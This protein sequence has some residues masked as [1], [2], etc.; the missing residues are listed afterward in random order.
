MVLAFCAALG[1]AIGVVVVFGVQSRGFRVA[2]DATARLN[3]LIFS[4]AYAGGAFAALFG[5]AFAPL[6]D[7]ARNFGLAFAAALTVH[8]GL[9]VCLCTTGDVPDGKVF[10]VFGPAAVLTYFLALLSL[11]RVRQAL[12]DRFWT[13]IRALA[14]NYIALAFLKDFARHGIGGLKDIV[15]HGTGDSYDIIM[16]V[17]FATLAIAG[18]MLRFAA[19]I[20]KFRRQPKKLSI[21]QQALS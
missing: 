19:W 15:M 12:P 3:L 6:R 10:V 16:Y 1:L 14:M 11:P 18:P 5:S 8:L 21:R 4:P 13:P 20:Q 7:N 2:L 17:P 9:V